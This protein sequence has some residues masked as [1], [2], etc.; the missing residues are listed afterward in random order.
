MNGN[1]INITS[2]GAPQ[3]GDLTWETIITKNLGL[4]LGF[5][6]NRLTA[7]ADFYIRDTKDML[8]PGTELPGV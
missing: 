2:H 4:D 3:S 6:G 8:I 1:K 7:T 5:F